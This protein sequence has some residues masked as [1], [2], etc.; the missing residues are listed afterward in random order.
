MKTV[1]REGGGEG[2][3]NSP[4]N[5]LGADE[6]FLLAGDGLANVGFTDKRRDGDCGAQGSGLRGRE[7]FRLRGRDSSL[8]RESFTKSITTTVPNACYPGTIGDLTP[9]A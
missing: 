2:G 1:K 3:T 4:D 9:K 8:H 6:D 5:S 7:R